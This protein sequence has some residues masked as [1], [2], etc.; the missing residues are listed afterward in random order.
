MLLVSWKWIYS[1]YP[2]LVKCAGFSGGSN[3]FLSQDHAYADIFDYSILTKLIL[4]RIISVGDTLEIN[5]SSD[6]AL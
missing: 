1:L 5:L 3:T 6:D 2:H 4:L